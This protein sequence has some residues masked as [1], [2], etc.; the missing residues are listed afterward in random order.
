MRRSQVI[1]DGE[2]VVGTQAKVKVVKNKLGAPFCEA[3]PVMI[4][5]RGFSQLHDL[6]RIGAESGIIEKAGSWFAYKDERLGQGTENA[7]EFLESHPEM[8]GEIYKLVRTFLMPD[9]Y[10]A[11]K[12]AK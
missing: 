3:E 8:A 12:E 11:A 2:K 5:G 9:I 4:F 1:K 6:L 7:V 10:P